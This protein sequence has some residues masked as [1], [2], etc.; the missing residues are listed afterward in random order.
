[1]VDFVV[2]AITI[3]I[4]AIGLDGAH[5]SRANFYAD[6][7]QRV[8]GFGFAET[9]AGL[10]DLDLHVRLVPTAQ[11][12]AAVVSGVERELGELRGI[13]RVLFFATRDRTIAGNNLEVGGAIVAGRLIVVVHGNIAI[14]IVTVLLLVRRAH[15]AGQQQHAEDYEQ[16]HLYLS[17]HIYLPLMTC[18]AQIDAA[19]LGRLAGRTIFFPGLTVHLRTVAA[20]HRPRK[21]LFA[22]CLL[23]ANFVHANFCLPNFFPATLEPPD[24]APADRLPRDSSR[25]PSGRPYLLPAKAG[26]SPNFLSPNCF[27]PNFFG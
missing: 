9:H 16:Q 3:G 13:E 11:Q 15:R 12:N 8:L 4:V 7:L 20:V 10:A 27:S 17:L 23:P 19:P 14:V 21:D 6:R 1:M 18:P 2:I 22:R 25:P 24:F 26:L 5:R